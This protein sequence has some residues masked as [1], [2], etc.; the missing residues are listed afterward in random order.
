MTERNR[1]TMRTPRDI[2]PTPEETLRPGMVL[3]EI[4]EAAISEKAPACPRCGHPREVE[5]ANKNTPDNWI[6]NPVTV[7]PPPVEIIST[8][9]TESNKTENAKPSDEWEV[10]PMVRTP[11]AKPAPPPPR[12][13]VAYV[14]APKKSGGCLKTAFCLILF[15]VGMA[16]LYNSVKNL[17]SGTGS[18]SSG[19]K[20]PL[21][22]LEAEG[23]IE[24][25]PIK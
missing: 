13:K 23:T 9:P 18:S 17:S 6:I 1:R 5:G 19:I 3:C 25:K 14:E 21:L 2:V 7:A 24:F 4:C 22:T 12:P 20:I 8:V 11:E 16:L 15:L 10:K